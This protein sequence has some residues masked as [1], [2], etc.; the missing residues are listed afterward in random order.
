VKCAL[1]TGA[2]AIENGAQRMAMV[3]FC[4]GGSQLVE[5]LAHVSDAMQGNEAQVGAAWAGGV[6]FYATRIDAES[7]K[8]VRFPL[9]LIM[10]SEDHLIPPEQQQAL[11]QVEGELCDRGV[12]CDVSIFKGQGHGFAHQDGADDGS[13]ERDAAQQLDIDFLLAVL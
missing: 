3:G 11:Q 13:G 9:K 4:Y 10:G 5:V 7:M 8:W 12:F 1:A 6:A 2:A